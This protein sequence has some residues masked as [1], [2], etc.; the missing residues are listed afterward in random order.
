MTSPP[1]LYSAQGASASALVADVSIAGT[2]RATR[3]Y[4]T[5]ACQPP[6]SSHWLVG[7]SSESG[8]S[9]VLTV[10]NVE[11]TPATV[12]IEV[13]T[14]GGKSGARSLT[15]IEIAARS[16]RQ[17]SLALVDPGRPMY[18]VHVI[19]TS[20]QVSAAIFDRG[21]KALASLG[22]DVVSATG[23]P[24]A[25]AIVGVLPDGS[26]DAVLG[27][28]APGNATAARVS[29][30]T[31]DG[32]YELAGAEN[33]TLDADKLTLVPIPDDA[34]VGDVAVLVQADT[35]V[36]AGVTGFIS[37]RGGPDLASASMLPP[38]YRAAS[39]TVDASVSMATALLYSDVDSLVTLVVRTGK[40]VTRKAVTVK[41]G[42]VQRVKL[43]GGSGKRHLV[44]VEPSVDG[45][46]RGAVLLQRASVGM[47]ATSVEP[48]ASVKGFVAV[49]PVAP[50]VTR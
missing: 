42:E 3:G 19:A 8:R 46:V 25:S 26:S 6:S 30:I 44:S 5:Y 28:L 20:G 40:D 38:I 31:S 50:A 9:A 35:P 11:D 36:I 2:T 34:L 12:D 47:V 4:A 32:T 14:E 16:R 21:Q 1:V 45:M 43:L 41:A 22:A 37:L 24:L 15:G 39:L 10:A 17:I 18:A 7:G 33:L 29:L 13:W 23:S 49:P 48:L 27:L